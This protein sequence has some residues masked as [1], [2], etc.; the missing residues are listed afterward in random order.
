MLLRHRFWFFVLFLISGRALTAQQVPPNIIF[1]LTDDLGYGDLGSFYQRERGGARRF[2]TP[3]L[4]QLA[5]TGMMLTDHYVSG[6]V[7]APSRASFLLGL[8]Q[9]HAPI[10]NNQFDK[11]LPAG[12]NVASLLRRAG[13]RTIHVGKYGL[14]GKRGSELPGHPLRRGFT[15]FYGF[16]H[17]V[18]GH[19][20]Y[21]RNGT[22]EKHSLVVDGYDPITTGTEKTYTTDLFTARAKAYLIEQRQNH[23]DQPLFL[24]LAYDT[25][26]S[27]LQLPTG[28]YPAG[29][30][31]EGGLV[32]TGPDDPRTPH[33]NTARGEIDSY[34]HPDYRDQDW[35]HEEK[36]FATMVRRID[37]AVGDLMQLL[38]DLDIDENTLVVFSSDNGPHNVN[39]QDPTWFR[40][41][42]PFTGIKRDLY[43]G[44]IRVPTI[45][46]WPGHIAPGSVSAAPVGNWDW[47][48][49]FA[50]V[51]G[52]AVPAYTDGASLLPILSGEGAGLGREYLYWEYFHGG[53]TPDYA[54]FAP[55]ARDR[56]RGE[57]QSVRIGN[58]KGVRFNVTEADAPFEIYHLGADSTEATDLARQKP[59]LQAWMQAISRRSR[60]ADPAAAR[61]YD[62][63]LVP[64][65]PP[66]PGL[67]AG[68]TRR[69]YDTSGYW[70]PG[71]PAYTKQGH[72]PSAGPTEDAR[73]GLP[74]DRGQE[75]AAYLRVPEDGTYTFELTANGSTYVRL[76]DIHLLH[77][78]EASRSRRDTATV[79]L[80]AGL[81]PITIRHEAPPGGQPVLDLRWTLPD[82][83]SEPLPGERLYRTPD[84]I[85]PRHFR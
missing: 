38:V 40:S 82:G 83:H 29:Y 5:A 41:Y 2:H 66:P 53:K 30:G 25:P 49:T 62:A 18:D 20:H 81:H 70:I 76:H 52:A 11:A 69:E 51:A 58:F 54:D 67:L 75:W 63:A 7:C 60:I 42:G 80:A 84:L 28:P 27:K 12:L 85:D 46:R 78:A 48:S 9:G 59:A 45:A 74:V 33:V 64:A 1:I 15:D 3:R 57:M 24:Y 23:P 39:G 13:Y 17:H 37:T 71:Q 8:H 77:Q 21:P 68:A 6:P 31:L 4:D 43:E 50:E 56:R 36:V 35:P 72:L 44:G 22:T 55:P 26:H 16:L 34:V 10:R 32:Y 47:L 65:L 14:A 73:A 19:E 61:P 79:H